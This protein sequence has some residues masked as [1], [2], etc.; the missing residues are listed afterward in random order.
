MRIEQLTYLIEISHSRSLNLA[1]E[2]LHISTQA[3]SASIKNLESEL[4]TI[5][6]NRTNRGITFT[7][8]GQRI[9][10]YAHTVI[11]EHQKLLHDLAQDSDE[12]SKNLLCGNLTLYS[13]PAFLES[14]VP[15]K[16]QEFQQQYPAIHLSVTQCSTHDICMNLQK[17][18][19]NT[20]KLGLVILPCTKASLLRDF[21]PKE[22]FFFRPINIGR[23][24]G[25]VPKDSPFAQ[26]KTISLNKLLKQ[27]IVIYT[28]GAAENSPLL[29]RL[30]QYNDH[31][32]ISSVV[33]SINFWARSIKNHLG[34]GFLN[35]IFLQPQSMVKDA[36]DDLVFI[37]I[38]EPLLTINGF[39]YTDE[40][41]PLARTFMQQFPVY[42]P[43]KNDPTFCKELIEL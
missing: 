38:N 13:A 11:N 39:I 20:S 7:E 21:L 42:H 33:S 3:L 40:P 12:V 26:H 32:Q 27:P 43:S 28:T 19:S 5:I 2:K 24:V 37:K 9:L 22:H 29:H 30:K 1:A 36:F 18:T 17:T 34:I 35:D 16:I 23:F 4:G 31:I 14:F 41:S 25:C 8:Q 10:Q 15:P 6:L